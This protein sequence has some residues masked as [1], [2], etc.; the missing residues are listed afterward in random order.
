MN[1]VVLKTRNFIWQI[2]SG[3]S[4]NKQQSTRDGQVNAFHMK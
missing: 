4:Q 2:R 3:R 1:K